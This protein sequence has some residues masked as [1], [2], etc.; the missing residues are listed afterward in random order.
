MS[1]PQIAVR[2]T[3]MQHVVGADSGP[4]SAIVLQLDATAA[5]GF[6]ECVHVKSAL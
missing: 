5:S 1:V 4:A 6:D 3:R 2:L